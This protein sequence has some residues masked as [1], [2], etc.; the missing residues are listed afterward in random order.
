MK[1]EDVVTIDRDGYLTVVGRVGDFIIRG[2]KNISAAAVEQAVL[3][4]RHVTTAAAV[5]MPDP[6]FGERVCVY[7]T[8]TP[9]ATLTVADLAA[10][11]RAQGVSSECFPERLIVMDE[12]PTVS[13]GKV[14]KHLL[15]ADIRTRTVA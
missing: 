9:G 8:L 14:A 3:K 4:H 1:M 2:G 7:L 13:G 5:A 12:L 10:F 15:R 6:V 11:L